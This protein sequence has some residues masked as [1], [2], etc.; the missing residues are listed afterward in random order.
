MSQPEPNDTEPT[1]E[2]Q[3]ELREAYER[4][5]AAD[6]PPYAGAS[7]H[8]RGELRWILRERHWSGEALMSTE[9]RRP[10][11]RQIDLSYA[12]LR[13]MAF[14]ETHF[15]G[16]KLVGAD[17][18]GAVMPSV[19]LEGAALTGVMLDGADLTGA[20]LVRTEAK[21]ISLVN[22]NLFFAHF[23]DAFLSN[24]HFAGANLRRAFFNEGSYLNDAILWDEHH[25][26]PQLADV[27]WG[28]VNLATIDWAQ[29]RQTGDEHDAR[30]AIDR[31]GKIKTREKQQANFQRAVRVNRQLAA[32]LRSQ[33]LHE[34]ADRFAYRAQY[35]KRQVLR[36]QR[37]VAGY[38]GSILLDMLAGYGYKPVRSIVAYLAIILGFMAAYLI[39][40]QFMAPHL[41]WDEALVLSVSSFHGRGFFA[42][43]VSLGDA[44]ARLAAAEA[45]LGLFVEISFI[46]TFTQRFF[47]K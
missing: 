33:G 26:S 38:L 36:R 6:R 24:A 8:T 17:L 42:T 9:E 28:N 47:A 5:I 31:E 41:S 23:E 18:R 2:R 13:N 40:G 45:I 4:N 30:K 14:V 11:L 25:L 37:N 39:N 10:D 21:N 16:A 29:I 19:H 15:E 7:I 3:T 1:P 43:N 35:L 34:D 27:R 12:N 20:Y 44:Y 46:A 32:A 22:A